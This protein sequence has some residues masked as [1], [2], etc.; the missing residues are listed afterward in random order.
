MKQQEDPAHLEDL[1]KMYEQSLDAL[2]EKDRLSQLG[3]IVKGL[4]HNINGPLQNLSML[5][6]MLVKGQDQ[7]DGLVS[8]QPQDFSENW[9]TLSNKQR[10]RFQRLIQ[11]ISI[12]A[13]MLRDFMILLE[14][15]RNESDVD[16][17]LILEKMASVFHSDLFFK[18][19]VDIELRLEK[20]LPLV[21]IQGREIIPALMHIFQNAITALKEAPQKKLTIECLRES[22]DSI[23]IIFRDSGCGLPSEQSEDDLY[24][25]FHSEWPETASDLENTEKHVGFGLYAV[26]QLLEPY[27]V[28]FRLERHARE[29][30]AILQIPVLSRKPVHTK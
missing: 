20:N 4:I 28:R 16:L 2:F 24:D 1:Q 10:Q 7:L 11:Q 23:R 9:E 15:E 12:L 25:L 13:E 26:R 6:E 30:L 18:H 3:K 29:T 14:I 17:N 27:G 21:P 8:K 5:V 19:Q 22:E